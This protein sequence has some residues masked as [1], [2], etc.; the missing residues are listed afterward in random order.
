MRQICVE[1]AMDLGV[2]TGIVG[3]TLC[4]RHR[5]ILEHDVDTAAFHYYNCEPFRTFDI[6]TTQKHFGTT[7]TTKT[8]PQ[9]CEDQQQ[10]G[11]QQR[12]RATTYPGT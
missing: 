1:C 12:Q 11:R 7:S 8:N 5:G 2:K 10:Y 6:R 3:D 9:I 4:V